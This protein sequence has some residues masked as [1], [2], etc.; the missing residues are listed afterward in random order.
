MATV[1]LDTRLDLKTIAMR[2]RN[3]EYNPKV[4]CPEHQM[5]Y[6]NTSISGTDSALEIA[7]HAQEGEKK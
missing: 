6:A 7:D 2:A 5:I 1:N 4:R 3:A